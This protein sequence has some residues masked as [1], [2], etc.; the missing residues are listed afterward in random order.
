MVRF[1]SITSTLGIA[2]YLGSAVML[3]ALGLILPG[4]LR[5]MFNTITAPVMGL[6]REFDRVLMQLFRYLPEEQAAHFTF[7]ATQQ[8]I[9]V[10]TL[11]VSSIPASLQNE[12][13]ELKVKLGRLNGLCH[14]GNQKK[15]QLRNCIHRLEVTKKSKPQDIEDAIIHARDILLNNFDAAERTLIKTLVTHLQ[16]GNGQ[17]PNPIL[18][19]ERQALRQSE[20]TNGDYQPSLQFLKALREKGIRQDD[21]HWQINGIDAARMQALEEKSRRIEASLLPV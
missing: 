20:G 16:E 2:L 7:E 13:S 10:P 1:A 14:F 19:K 18:T 17:S 3:R 9:I 12:A 5:R 15:A 8:N 4:P 6:T 21:G 11:A